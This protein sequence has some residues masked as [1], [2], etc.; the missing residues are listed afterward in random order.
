MCHIVLLFC[1]NLQYQTESLRDHMCDQKFW[2]F[3]YRW[4]PNSF[5]Y[6]PLLDRQE[7]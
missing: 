2:L 1:P 6:E 3:G 7:I 4:M 5:A